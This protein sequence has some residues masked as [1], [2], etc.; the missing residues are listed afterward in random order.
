MDAKATVHVGPFAR[1]GKRRAL[2]A[3]VAHALHPEATRTPVGIFLPT[4]DARCVD[5]VPST[6]TS[7]GLADRLVQ[8]WESVRAR[9][10]PMPTL[11]LPGDHGP[12]N[13]RRRTQGMQRRVE[14]V[15]QYPVTMRL[16][17]SP[18]YHRNSHPIERCWGLGE[19]QWN[20]SLLEAIDTGLQ[21]TAPMTWQGAHPIV[22]RVTTTSQTGV[23]LTK[24][25]M[26]AV[27]AQIKR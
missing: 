14:C 21:L 9:F 5:G 24:E 1:G 19:N 23:T 8:G 11:V 17:S 26:E 27:E 18:P 4:F 7:D 15:P 16:A 6:V 25:A 12:A 10:P 20:G 2:V 13:H 3:A 22:A